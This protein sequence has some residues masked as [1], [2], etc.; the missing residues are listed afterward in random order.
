MI[1]SSMALSKQ[2]AEHLKCPIEA[3]LLGAEAQVG[4]GAN[5][6]CGDELQIEALWTGEGRLRLGYRVVGCGALIAT[7]SL[8]ISR[9]Q[10]STRGEAEGFDVAA[11]VASAGGLDRRSA[12]AARVVERALAEALSP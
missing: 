7:A 5:A 4:L 9:L 11:V 1:R 6:A 10:G 2:L 8:C 3:K 12:H